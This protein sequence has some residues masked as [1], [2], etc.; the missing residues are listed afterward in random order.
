MNVLI[1][2]GYGHRLLNNGIL[3]SAPVADTK[4]GGGLSIVNADWQQRSSEE[5]DLSGGDVE[6]IRNQLKFL[7]HVFFSD[8]RRLPIREEVKDETPDPSTPRG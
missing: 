7:G 4:K 2:H 1:A 8:E 3:E 5:M 6:L